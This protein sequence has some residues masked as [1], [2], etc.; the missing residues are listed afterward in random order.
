VLG[1]IREDFNSLQLS[2]GRK[3]LL[4]L[5]SVTVLSREILSGAYSRDSQ[6]KP[7]INVV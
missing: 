3:L 6:L 4:F 1:A 5:S 2:V 7:T